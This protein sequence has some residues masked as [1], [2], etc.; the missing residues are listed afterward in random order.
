MDYFALLNFQNYISEFP[1][2]ILII[3]VLK[4]MFF[5]LLSFIR[6]NAKTIILNGRDKR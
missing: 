2:N 5:I 1:K 3:F 4:T 6:M